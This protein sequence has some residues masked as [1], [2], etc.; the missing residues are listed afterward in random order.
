MAGSPLKYWARYNSDPYAPLMAALYMYMWGVHS[1]AQTGLPRLREKNPV[2]PT[3]IGSTD[4]VPL[5]MVTAINAAHFY[6]DS[7]WKK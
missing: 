1:A 5:R 2:G 4:P 6:K 3:F 7:N